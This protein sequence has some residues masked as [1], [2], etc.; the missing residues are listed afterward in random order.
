MSAQSLQD[1]LL[2][3]SGFGPGLGGGGGGSEQPADE[4]CN[5]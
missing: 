5:T 4:E 2:Q 3:R 1:G